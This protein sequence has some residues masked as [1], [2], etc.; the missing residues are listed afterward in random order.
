MSSQKDE[1]IIS[2]AKLLMEFMSL[3]K[4]EWSQGFFRFVEHSD[5][6]ISSQ[7]SFLRRRE[8]CLAK[9]NSE[10]K[11]EYM[12]TLR[13]AMQQLFSDIESESKKRPDLA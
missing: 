2:M 12:E 7:W 9:V 8:L 3:T 4:L 1:L 10:L 13:A 5:T 11:G 6:H